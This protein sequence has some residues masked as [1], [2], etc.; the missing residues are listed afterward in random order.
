MNQQ[1]LFCGIDISNETIDICCQKADGSFDNQSLSNN[2]QGYAQ[3]LAL[4][5]THY[6][7][8]MEST[9]I[10]H[11]P[12]CFYLH[13]KQ[14]SFSVVNALQIKRYIQMHLERNKS[15][16]KDARY[17]CQYGI[18]QHPEPYEMPDTLYFECRALNK[19][20]QSI[21]NEI[22]LFKNKI[23]A[24]ERLNLDSKVVVK[25]YKN[26]VKQLQGELQKMEAELA[27]KLEHW[28]PEKLALVSS[29]LGIGK[30]ASTLL[31]VCTQGFKTT[32]SYQQ[33][34]SYAGLSPTEYSSG[35]SIRG[36]S[37]ICKKGG[38]HLRHTLYMCTLNAKKTNPQ[39]KALFDRL[40]A[41]GKN[42]KL[43]II[44]VCNKLLK[45]VFAVVKSGVPYD[46]NYLQ[47]NA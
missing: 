38:G 23:H 4:C 22:T 33:L 25:S 30:R 31:I 5:G 27:K 34:I 32:E 29:I 24:L 9:G 47:K 35:S 16:K 19:G 28:Q 44:A 2:K 15:D 8:V 7:F 10:Y 12:L 6:Q 17:I 21:S 36:R 43:A 39:C 37:R 42:K 40:V 18:D 20:I 14:R 26:I 45:Q 3:L 11:L 41:K 13:Q 1:T 46:R